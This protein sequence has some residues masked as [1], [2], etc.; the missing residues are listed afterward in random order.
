MKICLVMIVKDEA[1]VIERCLKSV[2]PIVD[3]YSIV[4]TGSTDE[5]KE[6]IK[7]FFDPKN[8]QGEIHDHPF[9]NFEDA[10]NHAILKAKD[11]ADYCFTIDADEELNVAYEFTREA[12]NEQLSKND[13]GIMDV[14]FESVTYSRRA[15]FKTQKPFRYF[16]AVHELLMC[17]EPSQEEK[18]NNLSVSVYRDG[19]SWKQDL[20]DKY[21]G[22]AKLIHDYIDANG[23]EPRHVFYLAQ[24][25]RDAGE[26]EKSIAWYQKRVEIT[27]GFFEE[28]YWSQYM[29]AQLKQ[30]LNNPLYE[31]V[32]EFLKCSEYDNMR[33]EHLYG[34]IVLYQKNNRHGSAGAIFDIYKK[35]IGKNPY[36]ERVLFIVPQVYE[37]KTTKEEQ[38]TT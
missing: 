5:T 10:R 22:H 18:I 15:F 4:D 36:P 38:P 11:K 32:D 21:L 34:L 16:G 37:Y 8:I 20:K 17:D 2:L 14:F 3:C 12:L 26:I 27:T 1:K 29:I 28:R 30:M 19:N 6:I 24:S 35:F 31:V 25:Y 9:V 33:A 7:K 23:M 13:A